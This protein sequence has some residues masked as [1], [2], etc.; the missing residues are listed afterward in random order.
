MLTNVYSVAIRILSEIETIKPS[1]VLLN[2][3]S[4]GAVV[5]NAITIFTWK[6]SSRHIFNVLKRKWSKYNVSDVG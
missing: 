5:R 1:F 6:I 3:K 4:L 2:I